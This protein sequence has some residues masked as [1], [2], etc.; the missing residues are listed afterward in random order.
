MSLRRRWPRCNRR[1]RY[2]TTPTTWT[3]TNIHTALL[4]LL[5]IGQRIESLGALWFSIEGSP[6]QRCVNILELGQAM[7]D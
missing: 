5:V 2:S 6:E 7:R 3:T 4:M 1:Q